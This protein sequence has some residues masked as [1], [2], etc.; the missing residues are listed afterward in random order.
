TPLNCVLNIIEL[1]SK[2]ELPEYYLKMLKNIKSSTVTLLNTI[3]SILD[4]SWIEANKITL[5][6]EVFNLYD[7]IFDANKILEP[8]LFSNNNKI[9]IKIDSM[10]NPFFIGSYNLLRQ[11]LINFLANSIKF[12]K[13]GKITLK[14]SLIKNNPESQNIH[15][16]I[17]DTGIGFKQS[18]VKNIL[19]P[20]VQANTSTSIDYGGSGLGLSIASE[21]LHMMGGTLFIESEENVGTTVSIN[22]ELH[23]TNKHD[24]FNPNLINIYLISSKNNEGIIY[25]LNSI[26]IKTFITDINYFNEPNITLTEYEYLLIDKEILDGLDN[27]T[28][29]KFKDYW[30][31]IITIGDIFDDNDKFQPLTYLEIDSNYLQVKNA[32]QICFDRN[33]TYV[34]PT[35]QLS[36]I[37]RKLNILIVDDDVTTLKLY[38]NY[39]ANYNHQV[40]LEKN[41]EIALNKLIEKLYD[42]AIVDYNLQEIS[43]LKLAQ[44][45]FKLY[46]DSDLKLI[47]LTAD[48]SK[49]SSKEIDNSIFDKILIKP[50]SLTDMLIEIYDLLDI[51]HDLSNTNPAAEN[52]NNFYLDN[53]SPD[54]SNE[55]FSRLEEIIT[56]AGIK[57]IK[58]LLDKYKL[59]IEDDI[60]SLADASNTSNS[61]KLHNI[62]HKINGSSKYFGATKLE[63]VTSSFLK[64]IEQDNMYMD[65]NISHSVRTA[66]SESIN[67]INESLINISQKYIKT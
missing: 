11:V 19:R 42:V 8:Q 63:I 2:E 50:I 61:T 39:F 28:L 67:Q 66:Y 17:K 14:V 34:Q 12:T 56:I 54:T 9:I 44:K 1:M 52:L 20:F 22:L 47:L 48:V 51:K 32:I 26:D 46:P 5:E 57:E 55:K 23:T 15:I 58:N 13:N 16:Q 62:L 40:D 10:C 49:L 60:S 27:I 29:L 24:Y 6:H 30:T 41:G 21:L 35:F 38:E 36:N 37:K 53:V 4:I 59:E 43:G 45:Y 7:L 18:K 33:K 64:K 3:N 65:P 25:N 31:H